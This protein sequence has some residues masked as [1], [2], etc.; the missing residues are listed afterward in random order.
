MTGAERMVFDAQVLLEA[1]ENQKAGAEALHAMLTAAKAL[2]QIQYD[3]VSDDDPD[4]IVEEFRERYYDTKLFFDP[5]ARGKFA[6]YLFAAYDRADTPFTGESAH[7][8][9]E[10]AQ[11][12]VEAVHSCYHRI[13][14]AASAN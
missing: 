10:E 7:Q 6:Q 1:N 11:L 9:I 8:T 5:Y 3:D 12:F 14:G 13:R 2:V 4:E